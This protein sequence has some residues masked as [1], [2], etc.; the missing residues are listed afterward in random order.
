MFFSRLMIG[1][2]S[3]SYNNSK[4][5]NTLT[6]FPIIF[7]LPIKMNLNNYAKNAFG[8][9][10]IDWMKMPM[11][12]SFCFRLLLC[13]SY[14]IKY[15]FVWNLVYHS[16]GFVFHNH[17][18]RGKWHWRGEYNEDSY[19]LEY[20]NYPIRTRKDFKWGRQIDFDISLIAYFCMTNH[21]FL[22][23]QI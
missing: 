10:Y 7:L 3:L 23:F 2:L 20:C 5:L 8:L 16:L 1:V 13:A 22:H 17:V 14:L 19:N 15:N 21:H 18:A 6:T 4:N 11:C 9:V 12:F